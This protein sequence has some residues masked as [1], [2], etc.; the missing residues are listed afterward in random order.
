V[1]VLMLVLVLVLVLVLFRV[2][3]KLTHNCR[4]VRGMIGREG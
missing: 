2:P 1:Q 3:Q 4:C